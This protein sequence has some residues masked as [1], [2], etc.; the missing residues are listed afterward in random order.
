MKEWSDFNENFKIFAT[1]QFENFSNL[2]EAIKSRFSIIQTSKYSKEEQYNVSQIYYKD[3]P[4]KLYTFINEY[5]KNVTKKELN[6]SNIIKI[7]SLY[8]NIIKNNEE[9]QEV[10][11]HK[12]LAISIYRVLFPLMKTKK[13]KKKLI[14][15]I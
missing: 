14:K 7:I 12:N 11:K 10:V 9:I 6:F 15:L 8:K 3:T 5:K 1:S 13:K 2:S 4:Y